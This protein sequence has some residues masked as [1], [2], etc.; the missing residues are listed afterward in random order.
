MSDINAFIFSSFQY[1]FI[2]RILSS[3]L[4]CF[5]CAFNVMMIKFCHFDLCRITIKNYKLCWIYCI[6]SATKS[7]NI[8]YYF[9]IKFLITFN[10]KNRITS[11]V[12]FQHHFTITMMFL[13]FLSFNATS[14]FII[15]NSRTVRD[16]V[17]W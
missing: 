11:F 10:F 2:M 14:L 5:C 7:F 1:F 8:F 9:N 12:A 4:F 15:I 16:N 3:N 13:N 6:N 17:K